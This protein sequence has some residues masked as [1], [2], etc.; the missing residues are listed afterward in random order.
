MSRIK[1]FP[2]A[3]KT[4]LL[5]QLNGSLAAIKSV[6]SGVDM[7]T[8]LF[9]HD[10]YDHVKKS[11]KFKHEFKKAWKQVDNELKRFERCLLRPSEGMPIFDLNEYGTTEE[12]VFAGDVSNEKYLELWKGTGYEM[13]SSVLPFINS[14]VHK[15]S[16]V[17]ERNGL[18]EPRTKAM[19]CVSVSLLS[20]SESIFKSVCA[21]EN[22]RTSLLISRY[23][24]MFACLSLERVGSAMDKFSSIFCEPMNVDENDIRNFEL[25]K[26]D[27]VE[28]FFDLEQ[29]SQNQV[30]AYK[31]YGTDVFADLGFVSDYQ[32][33]IEE[34]KGDFLKK[35]CLVRK[36][37]LEDGK[38]L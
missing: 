8:I 2:H 23:Q 19:V 30:T 27:I 13:Y 1:F 29:I 18:E 9:L 28:C 33:T 20:I 12:G 5:Q 4:L 22:D 21:A 26:S 16:R 38:N 10:T 3:N 17:L 37:L 25:S 32:K 6:M 31:D 15:V 24:D 35:R 7:T 36:E 11:K 14:Y 34:Q